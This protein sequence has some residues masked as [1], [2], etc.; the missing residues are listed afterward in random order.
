MFP[1]VIE[2]I[3]YRDRGQL[4]TLWKVRVNGDVRAAG[5]EL[6]DPSGIK[7]HAAAVTWA[8]VN[9]PD[10]SFAWKHSLNADRVL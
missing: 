10:V 3:A 8:I 5:E 6:D 4:R 1:N 9:A 7:A 2:T